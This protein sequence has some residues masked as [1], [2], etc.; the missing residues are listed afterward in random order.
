MVKN[1]NCLKIIKRNLK[2]K[3]KIPDMY[4]YLFY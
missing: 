2:K 1:K 3:N 4:A